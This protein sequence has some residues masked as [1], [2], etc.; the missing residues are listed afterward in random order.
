MKTEAGLDVLT[1]H[2]YNSWLNFTDQSGAKFFKGIKLDDIPDL[3]N[4]FQINISVF[5]LLENHSL[6]GDI[7]KHS[8]FSE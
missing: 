1:R 8:Q 2:K 5:Q 7:Q 4:C 6:M 3:E